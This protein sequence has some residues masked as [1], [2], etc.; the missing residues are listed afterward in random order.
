[1]SENFGPKE[2]LAFDI[3]LKGDR[4]ERE[5]DYKNAC[6]YYE[7]AAVMGHKLACYSAGKYY[8]EGK[9]VKQDYKKAYK[10]YK[11]AADK[12]CE[13]ACYRLGEL[14]EKGNGVKQDYEAAFKYYKLAADKG[15]KLACNS[16]GELY[17][18][19]NGVKQDYEEAYRYY[20]LA[21]DNGWRF[22]E[23]AIKRLCEKGYV[24][25]PVDEE[26]EPCCEQDIIQENKSVEEM[27]F[28]EET[29]ES[30]RTEEEEE[31]VEEEE[32]CESFRTEEEEEEFEEEICE[33]AETEEE[34][35][36][37]E[38]PVNEGKKGYGFIS[39]S[40][41]NQMAA[42][43][44]NNLL[45]EE[46]IKTWMAPNDIPAGGKYAQVINR[47]LKDC[48]CLI[49]ILSNDAQNST[50]VSKEVERAISY[51]KPIIPIQIEDVILN[52]EFEFYISTDQIVA[53]QKIDRNLK[54][55]KNILA[56]IKTFTS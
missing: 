26:T 9:G 55:I 54:E 6:K 4:C 51:N 56:S 52:D 47:A 8:E 3:A 13:Y 45:Q 20:K 38:E 24:A 35:E 27:V 30:F 11:M 5:Q 22:A 50:W 21:I 10:Y 36:P 28:V 49:L 39:Y 40:T 19:G 29:S 42:D 25:P 16:L 12:G 17:E 31:E 37:E 53:V 46:G 18:K 23:F 48:A 41:K 43:S 2:L 7:R 44:V 34:N 1:M 32:T 14:Y 33:P 15:Y